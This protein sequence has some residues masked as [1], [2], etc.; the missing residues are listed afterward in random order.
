MCLGVLIVEL[1][2]IR[3]ASLFNQLGHDL[4]KNKNTRTQLLS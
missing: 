3:G 4:E 1:D 2:T